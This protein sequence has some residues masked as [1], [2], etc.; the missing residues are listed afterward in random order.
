MGIPWLCSRPLRRLTLATFAIA[1]PSA[2]Y[3]LWHLQLFSV[4]PPVDNAG[5]SGL[6]QHYTKQSRDQADFAASAKK[7]RVEDTASA[8][9][10]NISASDGD[11][12]D[13]HLRSVADLE[14]KCERRVKVT[15]GSLHLCPCVPPGLGKYSTQSCNA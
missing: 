15:E 11:H 12:Y 7:I 1:A 2:V 5:P 6:R 14:S 3:L 13:L 10:S 9:D 4:A 8:V